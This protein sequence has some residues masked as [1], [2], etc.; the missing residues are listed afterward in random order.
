[1]PNPK[2]PDFLCCFVDFIEEE[3]PRLEQRQFSASATRALCDR[4]SCPWRTRELL[5]CSSQLLDQNDGNS[6]AQCL[7]PPT[8]SL[9]DVFDGLHRHSNAHVGSKLLE[10]S[11]DVV[12]VDGLALPNRLRRR[13]EF[14][15]HFL[16]ENEL[17]M[18]SR[19]VHDDIDGDAF[20][21]RFF[22][23]HGV[24]DRFALQVSHDSIVLAC[25]VFTEPWIQAM[26]FPSDWDNATSQPT[27]HR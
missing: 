6:G 26:R 15:M 2:H 13:V 11:Q 19:F 5:L 20:W 7:A 16:R 27:T 23:H 1:M 10:P 22:K 9:G 17:F 14:A 24:A 18:I 12:H 21:E 8:H 3:L 25:W 4:D